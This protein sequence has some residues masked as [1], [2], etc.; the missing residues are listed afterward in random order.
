MKLGLNFLAIVTQTEKFIKSHFF[1]KIF[2]KE[3]DLE[4]VIK[5]DFEV[6]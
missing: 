4:K 3:E 2:F 1:I 6:I 5:E